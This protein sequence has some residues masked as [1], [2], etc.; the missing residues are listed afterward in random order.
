[1]MYLIPETGM[2]DP[3]GDSVDWNSANVA[4]FTIN[5][6]ADGTGKGNFRYKVNSANAENFQSWT[7]HNCA[8]GS[9]G[10]WQLAF[11]NDTNVSLI[12]PDGTTKSLT[13]PDSDAANFQGG[14]IAYFGVRP[15]NETR[16][17]QSA[18]F[19][20]IKITGAAATLD[21]TF[22]SSGPPYVLDPAT[23]VKKA[24]SPQGIFITAPDAKYWVSWP[25]PDSGYT[26]LYTTDNLS[27][28][29]GS[30]WLGLPVNATGWLNVAGARR[31]T[32]VNQSAL[33]AA[34]SYAPTNCFFGLFH[35]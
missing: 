6:N 34:F 5:A 33:N 24:A 20:R 28:N 22:V 18:T 9:L 29:L 14:L 15:A 10:T 3:D 17:G 27:K 35:P 12:A 13:I 8:L 26:N 32:V 11:N 2:S 30:Q 16:I 31:L 1:M 4:Y 25:Q 23:W 7:D 19:S 21:D